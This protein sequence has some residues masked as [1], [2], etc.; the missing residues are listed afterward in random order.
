MYSDTTPFKEA[1]VQTSTLAKSMTGFQADYLNLFTPLIT[2]LTKLFSGS[3]IAAVIVLA[4]LAELVTLYP[5]I[6]LQLK[7]KKI[8][9]FHKKLVDRFQSGELSMSEG[10]RELDILYAVNESLHKKGASMVVFQLLIFTSVLA[11]LYLLS[12]HPENLST[13][14]NS[15]NYALMAKPLQAHLPLLVA[16]AYFLYAL[17]KISIKQKE[18]YISRAQVHIALGFAFLGSIVVF[19]FA[20]MFSVLLSIYLLTQITFSAMRFLIVEDHSAQW[21]KLAQKELLKMLRETPI[22]K[23]KLEH[24]SQ[25]FNHSAPVRHINFH[26]LEEGIS[27]SLALVIAL[28]SLHIL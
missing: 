22:K 10:K 23:N 12:F 5:A 7:Q 28:T 4:L 21:G 19:Y 16:L 18:D 1:A 14:F 8:H 24:V 17:I 6:L 25:K 27:M 3:L 13:Y 9:L 15:A 11:G 2:Q 20:G 26:L